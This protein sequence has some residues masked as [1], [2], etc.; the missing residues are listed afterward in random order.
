MEIKQN[1]NGQVTWDLNKMKQLF[2]NLIDNAVDAIIKNGTILI[3]IDK[4]SNDD[5]NIKIE[6][7]GMGMTDK[8]QSNVF[9]LYYTTKAKGT[10]IGL[11]IVQRII[12]EHNG[13]ISISSKRDVGTTISIILPQIAT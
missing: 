7:N 10:G 3:N 1:W 5:I 2:I 8:I 4:T 12:S 13:T 11:S 6:D 9:N